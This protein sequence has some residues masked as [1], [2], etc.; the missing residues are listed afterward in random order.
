MGR[1]IVFIY[2]LIAYFAF[3]GTIL[4]AIGFTENMVVPKGIDD[5]FED[6]TVSKWVPILINVL[7]LGV[8]GIQHSI[9]A[10]PAFKDWWTK[11]IPKPAERSTFVLLTSIILCVMFWQWR[12]MTT[13]LWDLETPALRYILFGISF[14]GWAMV[15]YSTFLID[16]FDLFGLRQVF[17]HL[18][19]KEYTD[20]KYAERSLYK[21]VR[22][23]L[24]L[25][26]ITAFWFTPTMTQ[27][28]L[29]FAVVTTAY[30]L[31]AIQL[32]ERDLIKGLGQD[33]VDYRKRTPM[34]LPIPKGKSS[35]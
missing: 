30:I 23:P 24:Y 33:Y 31:V 26:F 13:V 5:G 2:G 6:L 1:I 7:M 28:H 10:R 16:H 15:F 12:P 27:G 32:E 14:L 35:S 9:M 34:I 17:L 21:L 29:L 20:V 4:Y 8:F 19:G 22:H 18:Q 11:I 25:G 3:F